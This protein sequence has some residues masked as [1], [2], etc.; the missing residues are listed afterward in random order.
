MGLLSLTCITD[1]KTSSLAGQVE[2]IL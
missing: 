1:A 2:N